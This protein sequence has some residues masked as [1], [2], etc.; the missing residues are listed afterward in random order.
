[1]RIGHAGSRTAGSGRGH[2]DRSRDAAARGAEPVG[3]LRQPGRGPRDRPPRRRR[4]GRRAP[5]ARTAPGKTTT[6]KT[7]AGALSTALRRGAV[8]RRVDPRAAAPSGPDGSGVRSGGT[9]RL[10]GPDGRREPA[11]RRRPAGAR[12][13]AVPRAR[14]RTSNAGPACS[15]VASSRSSRWLGRWRAGPQVLLADELSL[16]LAPLVVTRLLQAVREAAERGVG[17]L[18]VEQHARQALA[19]ADRVYV[20][21]RGRIALDGHQP[22]EIRAVSTRSS[23]PISAGPRRRRPDGDVNDRTTDEKQ[24]PAVRRRRGRR[25]RGAGL[26]GAGLRRRVDGRHRP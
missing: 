15:R 21:Q 24:S 22:T 5:R 7:L 4:R 10:H 11:R 25:C 9:F 6:L 16:G 3:R 2:G 19:V 8:E 26:P 17:V 20:L 13:R 18:L 1:M 12:G 14:R 23:R